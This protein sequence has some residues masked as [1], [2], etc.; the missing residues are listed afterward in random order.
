[1]PNTSNLNGMFS[2]LYLDLQSSPVNKNRILLDYYCNALSLSQLEN[3]I[4][5]YKQ[6]KEMLVDK[7]I[8]ILLE[9]SI[10]EIKLLL[11]VNRNKIEKATPKN[12]PQFSSLPIA[13]IIVPNYLN[14]HQY[15]VD[16]M[17]LGYTSYSQCVSDGAAQKF[18]ENHGKTAV[19]L[20]LAKIGKDKNG[21]SAFFPSLITDKYC[22][23]EPEQKTELLARLCYKIPIIQKAVIADDPIKVVDTVSK[24]VLSESTA[25]RRRP[26]I[27]E[28]LAIALDQ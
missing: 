27:L 18:G 24:K 25:S 13:T 4:S 1:M 3:D 22:S 26:N 17:K 8:G 20:D 23:L 15:G 16:Y 6:K 11:A 9:T 28:L 14:E 10:E 7:L 12:I 5:V 2:P 21:K 19:L